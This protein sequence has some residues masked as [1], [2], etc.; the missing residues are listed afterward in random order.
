MPYDITYIQ[1]LNMTNT[2]I[3]VTE[4]DSQTENKLTVTKEG[5]GVEKGWIRSLG[6]AGA[7]QHIWNG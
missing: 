6:L 2:P 3:Y 4:T 5:A 7:N 1:N